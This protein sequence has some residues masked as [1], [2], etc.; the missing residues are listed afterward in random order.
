MCRFSV[1]LI[2]QFFDLTILSQQILEKGIV[3]SRVTMLVKESLLSSPGFDESQN[4]TARAE[5]FVVASIPRIVIGARCYAS[6]WCVTISG[7]ASGTLTTVLC[8]VTG[9]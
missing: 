9:R 3:H 4:V 1:R 8:S 7:T 2:W 6:L 5:S